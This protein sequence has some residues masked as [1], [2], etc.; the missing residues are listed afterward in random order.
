MILQK[1]KTE[2]NLICSE[3]GGAFIEIFATRE[4]FPI[5]CKDCRSKKCSNCKIVLSKNNTCRCGSIHG[6]PSLLGSLCV[7]CEIIS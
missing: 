1:E 4:Y 7:G 6:H 2:V 5:F 3:C